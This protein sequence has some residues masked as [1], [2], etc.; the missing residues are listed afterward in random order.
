MSTTYG[1]H[2]DFVNEVTLCMK[3]LRD[4]PVKSDELDVHPIR[5]MRQCPVPHLLELDVRE[6]DY[7]V[8]LIYDIS[9]K[10][11]LQQQLRSESIAELQY[12]ELLLQLLGIVEECR[13]YLLHPNQLL[14]HEQF[15]FIEG[16]L[17]HGRL[18]V[19]Y[20]PLQQAIH[21]HA[22]L[23]GIQHLAV[24]LSGNV[25][26][27]SGDRFQRVIRMLNDGS[28]SLSQVRHFLQ[29]ILSPTTQ[30]STYDNNSQAQPAHSEMSTPIQRERVNR[31]NKEGLNDEPRPHF[32][33]PENL[34]VSAASP[35]HL[36]NGRQNRSSGHERYPMNRIVEPERGDRYSRLGEQEKTER[37]AW[38]VQER[39]ADNG[40]IDYQANAVLK[41]SGIIGAA[42]SILILTAGWG[43]GYLRRNDNLGMVLSCGTTLI[44]L[45]FGW[46]WKKGWVFSLLSHLR[47]R[48]FLQRTDHTDP[49]SVELPDFASIELT[50]QLSDR[51]I[52]RSE[53]QNY[54][55]RPE[56]GLDTRDCTS[57]RVAAASL[58]KDGMRTGSYAEYPS[59]YT[60]KF[61]N[62]YEPINPL[63]QTMQQKEIELVNKESSANMSDQHYEALPFQTTMIGMSNPDATMM[64]DDIV[65]AGQGRQGVKRVMIERLGDDN[66]TVIDSIE[67]NEWPFVIGRADQG[68]HYYIPQMGISKLHCEL[69]NEET[70][71]SIKDL[72]SKNG[73]ELQDELLIPYK[74]YL[75][76]NG[77]CFKIG[78]SM[79]R[80]VVRE[81]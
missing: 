30:E 53:H 67:A 81:G 62:D 61:S 68:V 20:V 10:K 21:E 3:L 48:V 77:D 70:H 33:N 32:S 73:T 12:Y 69:I 76:Q 46:A 7:N 75:I 40:D 8:Q 45:W 79:L 58:F 1:Y 37:R 13:T 35:I 56:H 78:T 50:S 11:M 52:D 9:G 19:P 47:D 66:R 44:G 26:S 38:N 14:L 18:Y 57:E 51:A 72:G 39:I 24:Q 41:G 31:L 23:H 34:P 63:L 36:K 2:G 6:I 55:G 27:W 16:G 74:S 65:H 28:Y 42:I 80:M 60:T 22:A 49:G 54:S 4:P 5:M 15:V 71:I 29:C 64:L 59:T 25:H 17:S 43:L